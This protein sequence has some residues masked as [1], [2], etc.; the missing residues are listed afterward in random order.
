MDLDLEALVGWIIM[1]AVPVFF[2]W[3]MRAQLTN[4]QYGKRRAA[5]FT[6]IPFTKIR[7]TLYGTGSQ[8]YS[9][10][11]TAGI[12]AICFFALHLGYVILMPYRWE[13]TKYGLIGIVMSVL[14]VDAT[15]LILHWVKVGHSGVREFTAAAWVSL[16][17]SL[18]VL[19]GAAIIFTNGKLLELLTPVQ[20]ARICAGVIILAGAFIVSLVA[21]QVQVRSV[22]LI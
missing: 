3:R 12:T 14:V 6:L 22:R 17:T 5:L 19:G 16:M 1:L 18:L 9:L 2:L 4:L 20:P 7:V 8:L 21:V 13:N 15:A 10:I 11:E